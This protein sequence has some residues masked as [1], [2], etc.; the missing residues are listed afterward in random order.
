MF[1]NACQ[2]KYTACSAPCN[3]QCMCKFLDLLLP[4]YEKPW[5]TM[6]EAKKQRAGSHFTNVL[7]FFRFAQT[8]WKLCRIEFSV[9]FIL[10]FC[11]VMF[12]RKMRCNNCQ[13]ITRHAISSV[14]VSCWTSRFQRMKSLENNWQSKKAGSTSS[15]FLW[16][17]GAIP[18]CMMRCKCFRCCYS[19]VLTI[20]LSPGMTN[21]VR[22]PG[23]TKCQIISIWD[24]FSGLQTLHILLSNWYHG[25]QSIWKHLQR[26]RL[27][28]HLWLLCHWR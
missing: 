4:K 26:M 17:R 11:S 5:G 21:Q 19:S 9:L 8:L 27:Q 12:C 25:S 1:C 24:Y 13:S 16:C 7:D 14:G 2:S 20:L 6:G 15:L 3:Q 28:L 10:V 22:N 18:N 23:N